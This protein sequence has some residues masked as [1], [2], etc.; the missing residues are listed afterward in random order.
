MDLIWTAI[1]YLVRIG[2]PVFFYRLARSDGNSTRTSLA[3]AA[4][5]ACLFQ[6]AEASLGNTVYLDGAAMYAVGTAAA[7]KFNQSSWPFK[8]PDL[9]GTISTSI[10][11]QQ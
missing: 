11:A 9:E 4:V 6:F 1:N 2:V 8:A 10:S 3:G 5:T 7:A